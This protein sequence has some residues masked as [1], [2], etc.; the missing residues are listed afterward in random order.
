MEEDGIVGKTMEFGKNKI[1]IWTTHSRDSM[2]EM[3]WKIYRTIK[4]KMNK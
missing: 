4:E 3:K 2:K 1:K